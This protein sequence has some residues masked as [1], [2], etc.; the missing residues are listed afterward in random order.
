[1]T[2]NNSHSEHGDSSIHA[3]YHGSPKIVRQ[4]RINGF[5]VLAKSVE[6][7]AATHGVVESYFGKEHSLQE[8]YRNPNKQSTIA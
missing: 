3:V 1:M 6:E 2:A 4:I 5:E 8:P 7:P